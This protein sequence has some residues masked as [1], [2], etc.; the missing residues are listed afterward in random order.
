[1]QE[2]GCKPGD[3]LLSNLN[4]AGVIKALVSTLE[5]E[6]P[7]C[8]AAAAGALWLVVAT[9]SE[10]AL[11]M[12]DSSGAIPALVRV[13]QRKLPPGDAD[14]ATGMFRRWV[15]YPVPFLPKR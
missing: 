3:N 11:E 8:V 10:A 1:L 2:F 5:H 9:E 15:D 12:F 13:I 6:S 7:F 14:E 4:A